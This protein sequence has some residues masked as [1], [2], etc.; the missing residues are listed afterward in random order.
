MK[1]DKQMEPK[2]DTL[3]KNTRIEKQFNILEIGD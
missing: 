1:G 3:L 2:F